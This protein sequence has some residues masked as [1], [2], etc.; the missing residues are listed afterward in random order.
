MSWT[1][2]EF[3]QK[4]AHLA[5]VSSQGV[6][7][8]MNPPAHLLAAIVGEQNAVFALTDNYE[9]VALDATTGATL[10]TRP[11]R[12][13]IASTRGGGVTVLNEGVTIAYSAS[14][15]IL[16]EDVSQ[17]GVPSILG[18]L[19]G[20]S[21]EESVATIQHTAGSRISWSDIAWGVFRGSMLGGF[22][23]PDCAPRPYPF[24]HRWLTSLT[25]NLYYRF[26][27]AVPGFDPASQS[28]IDYAATQWLAAGYDRALTPSTVQQPANFVLKRWAFPAPKLGEAVFPE[29]SQL[30]GRLTRQAAYG[31][32]TEQWGVMF[33]PSLSAATLPDRE[34]FRSTAMH[35]IG[36]ILGLSHVPKECSP[37][38][39]VMTPIS[40]P[41]LDTTVTTRLDRSG[42]FFL[43]NRRRP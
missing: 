22:S 11:A 31:V 6:S 19:V 29:S 1:D 40:Y 16:T 18:G 12:S 15:D 34:A 10:W 9:V 43:K 14:G 36:H 39:T 38:S 32:P 8:L 33:T 41:G 27:S 5:K 2:F 25:P 30:A 3:P 28:V 4:T 7:E 20:P 23:G 13:I 35:E 24:Y 42:I 21:Y 26:D 17:R 37:M